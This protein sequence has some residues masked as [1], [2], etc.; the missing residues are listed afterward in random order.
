M[1]A[2]FTYV[3]HVHNNYLLNDVRPSA[4]YGI[5]IWITTGSAGT[6]MGLYIFLF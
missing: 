3:I 1:Y 6:P 5:S 2:S 4:K